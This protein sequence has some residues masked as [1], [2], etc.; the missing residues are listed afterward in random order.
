MLK[1]IRNAVIKPMPEPFDRTTLQCQCV[2]NVGYKLTILLFRL[3]ED[4][5][6]RRQ[7]QD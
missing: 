4:Y 7:W 3:P 1:A 5:A 6:D 2:L